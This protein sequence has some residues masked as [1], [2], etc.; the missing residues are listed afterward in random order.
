MIVTLLALLAAAPQEAA[1]ADNAQVKR[2]RSVTLTTG[3]ACP[4]ST[5]E[6]IVVC[7][8]L[9][10]PYRIPKSLREQ[11]KTTVESTAW[12]VRVDRVME[13]NRKT[14]PGSCSPIGAYGQS[15][16]PQKALDAW[17]AEQRAKNNG[18][19]LTPVE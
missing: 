19:S 6:E 5:D 4:K 8:T 17:A 13:D 9:E 3:Q 15:G 10:E 11:P 18:Q 2:V 16:C 14:L 7:S 1:P 12:G